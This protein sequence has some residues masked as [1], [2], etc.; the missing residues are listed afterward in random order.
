MLKSKK[1][2]RLYG[3]DARSWYDE[4]SISKI[5]KLGCVNIAPLSE[6]EEIYT[7]KNSNNEQTEQIEMQ[8]RI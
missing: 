3:T 7:T 2:F 6:F 8:G 4:Y 1:Q 5:R